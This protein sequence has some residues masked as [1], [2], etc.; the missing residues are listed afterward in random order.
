[1][2]FHRSGR[3]GSDIISACIT[4]GPSSGTLPQ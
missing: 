1:M 4:R 3:W 2:W